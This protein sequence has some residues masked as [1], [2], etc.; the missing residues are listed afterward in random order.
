MLAVERTHRLA[1]DLTWLPRRARRTA[2]LTTGSLM[3]GAGAAAVG[4]VVALPSAAFVLWKAL[5]FAGAGVALASQRAGKAVLRRQIRRMARGEL[6]LAELRNREDGE[7]VVVRGTVEADA[8]LR[9]LLVAT[10]GVFRRLDLRAAGKWV[11]EA[12]T[13]F[14]LVDER[15]ERILV[16]AAGARWL[17]PARERVV[18]PA[19][20]IEEDHIPSKVRGLVGDAA[21]FEAF[22]QVLEVG[23]HVQIVGYKTT[24]PDPGG[25]VRDYRTAPER[26]TLRSGPTLPLVITRISDLAD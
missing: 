23:T 26:A 1:D 19:S 9:G 16:E 14:S 18:Y 25:D 17:V 12:A 22:E 4:G 6:E 10:E 11:H 13:N 5:V 15:G 24:S 21:S 8:P 3:L 2:Q 7:L 20:R